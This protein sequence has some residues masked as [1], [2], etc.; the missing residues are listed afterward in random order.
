MKYK[1]G[2]IPNKADVE[3]IYILKLMMNEFKVRLIKKKITYYSLMKFC[4][5]KGLTKKSI[6]VYKRFLSSKRS[7]FVKRYNTKV[8]II[9]GK[10]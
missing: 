4:E 3:L 7:I 6:N 9:R 5:K 10:K 2:S 8:D 1:N